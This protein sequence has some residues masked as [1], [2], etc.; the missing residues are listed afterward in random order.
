MNSQHSDAVRR[1]EQREA[2]SSC[3]RRFVRIPSFRQKRRNIGLAVAIT[4]ACRR[5]RG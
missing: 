3:E 2:V 4:C 5:G 1:K